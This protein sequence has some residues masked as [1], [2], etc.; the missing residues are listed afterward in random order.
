MNRTARTLSIAGA[1]AGL[2]LAAA[3]G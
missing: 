3:C 1:T 2:L